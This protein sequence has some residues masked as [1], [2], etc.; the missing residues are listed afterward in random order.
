MEIKEL[1]EKFDKFTVKIDE[2]VIE[3]SKM[4]AVHAVEIQRNQTDINSM[5]KKRDDDARGLEKRFVNLRILVVGGITLITVL[6]SIYK[7]L[8]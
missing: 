3:V 7:F 2:F 5:G 4:L 6:I 1:G 8:V